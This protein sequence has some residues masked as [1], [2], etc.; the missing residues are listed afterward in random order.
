LKSK[1]CWA[2]TVSA[3]SDMQENI[4][5]TGIASPGRPLFEQMATRLGVPS[6]Y[7]YQ[8]EAVTEVLRG[9]DCFVVVPTGGGK[10]FCYLIP[11]LV[12]PG[13]VLVVSPL[14]ALMRDQ[15]RQLQE[16]SIPSLSFDSMMSID[17]KRGA[18]D[19]IL[20]QRLKVLYVSPERLALPGFRDLLKDLPLALIAIDEAHCVHEWGMG[21]RAEYRRLGT[22]LDELGPAPRMAL[23]ATVTAEERQEII[24]I[25]GMRQPKQILRAAPRNNL[26]LI[27]HRHDKVDLQKQRV[28]ASLKDAEGQGIV[29][30][31]TRKS[32]EEIFHLLRQ[33]K[34]PV[35]LYHGGMRGDER[36]RAQ[37]AFCEKKFQVMVATK[38][39]GM[40]INLPSIR[41]VYHANMPCSVESYT[42]EIGRA[43][44]DGALALCH[45]HY[46]PRDYYIQKFMIEKSYPSEMDLLKVHGILQD[47]LQQRSGYRETEL[48][49]KLVVQ[50]DLDRDTIR[51]AMDFLFREQAFL[52]TD[53]PAD[54][55][56][57]GDWESFVT[58]GEASHTL[59]SLLQALRKQV[60]WKFDKLNAMHKLVKQASCPRRYIEGYFR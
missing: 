59:D 30:A 3:G 17:E 54:G 4:L 51:T 6:L 55:S 24:Q 29:Y 15:Q 5:Q 20:A 16:L 7:D 23:T 31:S 45:L 38:A 56:I 53:L 60:A 48:L 43:G 57:F 42:Q 28:V 32:A 22:Y 21:F 10:S 39:F 27:V 18:R 14:I 1:D 58:T 33:A 44:R 49:Q 2:G 25:L 11:A 34:I 9:N 52:L 50:T 19:Q 40:G 41:Y 35:G 26:E 46:G 37:E 13:L 47:L 36:M 12:S 8:I